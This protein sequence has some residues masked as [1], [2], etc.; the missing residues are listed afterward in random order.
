[1]GIWPLT[2][3][4]GAKRGHPELKLEGKGHLQPKTCGQH[5]EA[6]RGPERVSQGEELPEAGMGP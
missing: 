1:M 6:Q 5:A 2:C 4:M 3:V